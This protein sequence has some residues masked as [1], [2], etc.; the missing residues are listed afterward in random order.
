MM[1][2]G[3]DVLAEQRKLAPHGRGESLASAAVVDEKVVEAL[4]QRRFVA[5]CLRKT[6]RDPRELLQQCQWLSRSR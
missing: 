4:G 1:A 6:V 2:T 5:P 3:P